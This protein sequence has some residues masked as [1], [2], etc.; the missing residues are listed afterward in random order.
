MARRA[1]AALVGGA[2]ALL[3]LLNSAG[4]PS[5]SPTPPQPPDSTGSGGASPPLRFWHITDL[6][7]NLWHEPSGDA[8]DM[9]RSAPGDPSRRPGPFGHFNCD[10]SLRVGELMIRRM[11]AVEPSPAFIF[12]GGDTF[13]HV[14]RAHEDAQGVIATHRAVAEALRRSFPRA[15]ILPVLGNHDTW[16]YFV[17][18][19]AGAE[20]AR[21]QL[22]KLY[23]RSKVASAAHGLPAA[24]ASQM[25]SRGYYAV[26]LDRRTWLLALE[27]NVLSLASSRAAAAEQL[28][29]LDARL[30][31][32]E[33]ANASV[34]LLGHIAPGASHVDYESMAAAGWDGGGWTRESQIRFYALV[35]RR[36]RLVIAMFFGHHHT[37]SV[38]L[39]SPRGGGVEG[40]GRE[41][42]ARVAACAD[43][44]VMYLGASLT[45]RNPTPHTPAVRLVELSAA[46][47]ARPHL[48]DVTDHLLDVDASNLAAKPVWSSSSL[49]KAHGLASLSYDA[50]AAWAARLERD[51]AFGAAMSPQRCADEIEPSYA[52]CKAAAVC[53][54]TELEVDPY[55]AC[56][57]RVRAAA[58][59]PAGWVPAVKREV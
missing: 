14:P 53:A 59:A 45:P 25:A 56:L 11:A 3:L 39:L 44:P 10:P 4:T 40:G 22:A 42:R 23:G 8:R 20:A 19:G 1:V 55:A 30:G 49:R 21:R 35:R 57:R 9:C 36:R 13:G 48:V 18:H 6:H 41:R 27:T 31:A 33:A 2:L 46:D 47:G 34:V 12:M 50:W 29:W 5:R 43:C 16:P 38:R 15:L 51:A 17:A 24:A 54:L 26:E 28:S 32:A 7:L 37:S 52:R 58:V